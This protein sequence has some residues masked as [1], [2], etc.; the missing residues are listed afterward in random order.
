[1]VKQIIKEAMDK[2]PIG[3]KKALEEELKAR[4]AL[5]L[6]A[7]KDDMENDEDEEDEEEDEEENLDEASVDHDKMTRRLAARANVGAMGQVG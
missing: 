2:N 4:V 1:V 6:E 3:L 5:A 7:K